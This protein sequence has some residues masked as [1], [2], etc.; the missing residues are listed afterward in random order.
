[1]STV[2]QKSLFEVATERY[3]A[4]LPLSTPQLAELLGVSTRTVRARVSAGS[5]P[6]P[7]QR[8]SKVSVWWFAATVRPFITG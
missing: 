4:G 6:P 2:S 1:M 7:D 8:R 3:R 5:L